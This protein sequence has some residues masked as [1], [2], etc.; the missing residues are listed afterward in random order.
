VV[1][2]ALR[3]DQPVPSVSLLALLLRFDAAALHVQPLVLLTPC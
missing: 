3:I 2:A 1:T